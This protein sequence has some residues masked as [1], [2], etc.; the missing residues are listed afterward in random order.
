L[1]DF[2]NLSSWRGELK[3][4]QDLTISLWE[5]DADS[6]ATT[7]RL[8]MMMLDT[9]QANLLSLIMATTSAA[10][11]QSDAS[12]SHP[13]TYDIIMLTTLQLSNPPV[14]EN[15]V[16]RRETVGVMLQRTKQPG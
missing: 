14:M 10:A 9:I 2:I 6:A 13:A 3:A 8:S 15:D 5:T 1:L 12:T 7:H 16:A 11:A 4:V